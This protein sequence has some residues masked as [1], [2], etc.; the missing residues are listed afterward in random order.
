M[1]PADVEAGRLAGR[2]LLEVS[3]LSHFSSPASAP[4]NVD[5]AFA[6]QADFV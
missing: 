4:V 6:H 1:R 5:C 2:F 3:R